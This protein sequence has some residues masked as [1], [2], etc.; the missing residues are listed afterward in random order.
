MQL[1]LPQFVIEQYRGAAIQAC[2]MLNMQPHA[3]VT[4][5]NA[6]GRLMEHWEVIAGRMHEMRIYAA[7]MNFNGFPALGTS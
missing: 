3:T 1:V 5:I 2:M 7:A 6:D 4:Q